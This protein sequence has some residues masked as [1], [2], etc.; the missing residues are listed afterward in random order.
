MAATAEALVVAT[1]EASVVATAAALGVATAEALVVAMA[2]V[3][4]AATEAVL[5]GDMAAMATAMA[6]ASELATAG[7]MAV[8][9][10]YPMDMAIPLIM[11]PKAITAETA[12]WFADA[13]GGPM[14][15]TSAEFRFVTNPVT[16]L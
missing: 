10:I 13:F 4:E 8:M 14:D 9:V 5:A 11:R 7:F 2:E 12:I 1:A 3:S 6:A 16:H 15:P